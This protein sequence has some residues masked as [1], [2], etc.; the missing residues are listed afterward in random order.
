MDEGIN[1]YYD[2]RYS[3]WKYGKGEINFGSAR[4]SI[5]NGERILFETK[6]AD[7]KDQPINNTI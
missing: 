7:K 5:K 1:T 4:S 3:Q 6:A 2:N